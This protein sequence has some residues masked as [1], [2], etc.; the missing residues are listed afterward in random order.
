MET[1]TG[2]IGWQFGV[3]FLLVLVVAVWMFMRVRRSQSRRGEQP[4]V[5][6]TMAAPPEQRTGVDPMPDTAARRD[7]I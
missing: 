1:D 5:P 3:T 4:G 2:F 7:R 6:G